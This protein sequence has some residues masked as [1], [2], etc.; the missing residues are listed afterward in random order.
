[1]CDT[2][3]LSSMTAKKKGMCA[4]RLSALEKWM[5]IGFWAKGSGISEP[6]QCE[7]FS[8]CCGESVSSLMSQV[9]VG[10]KGAHGWTD[11]V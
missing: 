2:L 8:C 5:I 3:P 11:T 10:Y 7:L 1:M 9:N 6:A 4:D